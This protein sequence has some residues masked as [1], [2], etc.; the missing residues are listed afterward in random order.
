MLVAAAT[1]LV[2]CSPATLS[3]VVAV[4]SAESDAGV[5]S[6][7]AKVSPLGQGAS[8]V[9]LPA[10]WDL[11]GRMQVVESTMF[12]KADAKEMRAEMKAD[13][14]KMRAE[15]KADTKEMRA[16]TKADAQEMRAEMKADAQEMQNFNYALFAV[17]LFISWKSGVE[18]DARMAVQ[19]AED[20]KRMD[21]MEDRAG[22]NNALTLS[23]SL[24]AVLVAAFVPK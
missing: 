13:V 16:E 2:L 4:R 18:R 5:I 14:Q 15:M 23:V 20:M 1:S 7:V 22:K 21:D 3:A 6:P 17:A 19:R 9:S 24:T 11:Y 12:T 8:A 10:S